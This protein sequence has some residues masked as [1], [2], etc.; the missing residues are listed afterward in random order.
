MRR[1]R[2]I[3]DARSRREA[4]ALT[5]LGYLIFFLIFPRASLIFLLICLL[6]LS[7]PLWIFYFIL[8]WSLLISLVI[9]IP[10][11]IAITII[12]IF[13]IVKWT[14]HEIERRQL[15]IDAKRKIWEIRKRKKE[16][17]RE[18]KEM[19]ERKRFWAQ[20]GYKEKKR[21]ISLDDHPVRATVVGLLTPV[22]LFLGTI[23]SVI[24]MIII[25]IILLFLTFPLILLFDHIGI[26]VQMSCLL[27]LML[28][29]A[30]PISI[31]ILLMFLQSK[32]G[33][34][35]DELNNMYWAL[36]DRKRDKPVDFQD[37]YGSWDDQ[38]GQENVRKMNP[39]RRKVS[40]HYESGP[41]DPE[42]YYRKRWK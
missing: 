4:K 40:Q 23:G 27:S 38:D 42:D 36:W 22:A 21:T 5:F 9:E 11:F 18:Y 37:E 3:P 14:R 6:I 30:V 13:L 8:E 28:V 19:E 12:S 15:I 29:F 34:E 26:P 39:L 35:K 17:T 7:L 25:G 20:L 1:K 32:K 31:I 10:Y 2:S 33:H 24:L 41:E 16:S